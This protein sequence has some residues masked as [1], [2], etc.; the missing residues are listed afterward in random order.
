MAKAP[1]I[2][3]ES[4]AVDPD[5]KEILYGNKEVI[6]KMF[7][8]KKGTLDDWLMQMRNSKFADGVLNPTHKIVLIHIDRFEEFCKW[9]DENRFKRS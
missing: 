3:Y 5:R 6:M 4:I 2:D 9:K 7:S 1:E 8:L